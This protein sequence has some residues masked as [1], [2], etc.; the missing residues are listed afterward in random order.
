[1]HILSKVQGLWNSFVVMAKTDEDKC[2]SSFD[3]P[4]PL[5]LCSVPHSN[6]G[7]GSKTGHFG[8][9]DVIE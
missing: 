9:I 6:G 5:S 1:M 8:C 3:S 2:L 7:K 4:G